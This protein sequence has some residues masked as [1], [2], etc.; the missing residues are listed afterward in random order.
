VIDCSVPPLRPEVGRRTP[1]INYFSRRERSAYHS[2]HH[3]ETLPSGYKFLSRGG[4]TPIDL[5]PAVPDSVSAN[6]DVVFQKGDHY[7]LKLAHQGS[8]LGPDD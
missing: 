6:P 5:R 1:I 4:Q 8:N 3:G 2:L 7:E